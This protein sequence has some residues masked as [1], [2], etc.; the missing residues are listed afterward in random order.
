MFS[1]TRWHRHLARTLNLKAPVD[2]A[3]FVSAHRNGAASIKLS[4]VD[5]ARATAKINEWRAYLPEACVAAMLND[6]WQW[7]T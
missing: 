2:Y 6:G 4:S 5:H 7:T 3:P 1:D